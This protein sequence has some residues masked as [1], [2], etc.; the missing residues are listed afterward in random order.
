[1]LSLLDSVVKASFVMQL[2][3]AAA[4]ML[5]SPRSDTRPD[6]TDHHSRAGWLQQA[7]VLMQ[8]GKKKRIHGTFCQS[9]QHC[10]QIR[11]CTFRLRLWHWPDEL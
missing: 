5:F 1:M 4:D 2:M 8:T 11:A 9:N 6:S 10:C 7:F 3:V